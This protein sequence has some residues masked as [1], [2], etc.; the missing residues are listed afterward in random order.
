MKV[1]IVTPSFNQGR[2]I[3]RTLQSVAIQRET[4]PSEV[5][6]EHVV[7]DGGSRDDTVDI[8]R[9]FKP[10][11]T[12]VSEPDQGQTHA[13]N[14]GLQST[15]GEIIGWLNSD[16]VYY[17]NAIAR[18]VAFFD[19]HPEIDVVYGMA[20]HIDIDDQPFETYPSEPWHFE[21][22]KDVCFICQPALFFRR[23]V[24]G[25]FGLLDESLT[26]CMDYEFWLRLA[27]QDVQFAYLEE[28]LAG[29]RLY[30]DNKTLG[31]RV[32]VHREINDMFKKHF[33]SVPDRW[34]MNYAHAVVE[35]E[36]AR[37][38]QPY[39]FVTRLYFESIAASRAWNGRSL[40]M[41]RNT[42]LRWGKAFVLAKVCFGRKQS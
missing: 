21:R 32:E 7:F 8:L 31:A 3:E 4:M 27:K 37:E 29:S 25:K 10:H 26:Y 20:D 17:P 18:V 6:L 33:A 22:L 28:K 2:F 38:Q 30:G 12:W 19:N 42:F 9:R 14:K 15:D 23:R 16:D 36:L 39:R 35:R 34:I 11:V 40:S 1:S 5:E 24:L 13:V 41:V